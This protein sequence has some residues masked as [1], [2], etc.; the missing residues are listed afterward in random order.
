MG[1]V[2]IPTG[3]LRVVAA[4][5]RK[6]A[7]TAIVDQQLGDIRLDQGV[8]RLPSMPS[9]GGAQPAPTSMGPET[10]V[11]WIA[12]EPVLPSLQHYL[13]LDATAR[14]GVKLGDRLTLYRPVTKSDGGVALPEQSIAQATVVRVTNY[15]I[16]ALVHA[17]EMPAIREGTAARVSARMP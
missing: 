4:G 8:I 1:Q 11:V 5:R 9:L 2:I 10:R 16:T 3:I 12:S 17:Q 15:G 7:A 14:D 13:V 6:T